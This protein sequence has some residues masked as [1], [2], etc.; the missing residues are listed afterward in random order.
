MV[1][2]FA[3]RTVM[4]GAYLDEA[5]R[6]KSNVSLAP[7]YSWPAWPSVPMRRGLIVLLVS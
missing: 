3:D 1:H 4:I 6:E 5:H 7:T 2:C